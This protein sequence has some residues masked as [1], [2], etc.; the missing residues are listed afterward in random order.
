MLLRFLGDGSDVQ[1]PGEVVFHVPSQEL[2][3]ANCFNSRATDVQW[4]VNSRILLRILLIS[5][6]ENNHTHRPYS[7]CQSID[8]Y[9]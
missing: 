8:R 7:M 1:G 5:I 9:Q 3:I 6:E 2:H 4:G